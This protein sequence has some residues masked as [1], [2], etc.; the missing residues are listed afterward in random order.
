[1]TEPALVEQPGEVTIGS[2]STHVSP[3]TSPLMLVHGEAD[4]AI[5]I[6]QPE[7][8][9][10]A[11]ERAGAVVDFTPI[12]GTGHFFDHAAR[13]AKTTAGIGFLHDHLAGTARPRNRRRGSP[14]CAQREQLGGPTTPHPI[15][16][17]WHD[18]GRNAYSDRGSACG[19]GYAG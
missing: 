12:P 16:T 19:A 9:V 13:E 18:L 14:T 15:P 2:T 17:A 8:L 3:A 10:S 5:P 6:D 1:M 4:T 7:E 11:Y